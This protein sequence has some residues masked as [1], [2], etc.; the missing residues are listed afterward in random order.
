MTDK[1]GKIAANYGPFPIAAGMAA[2]RVQILEQQ[3]ASGMFGGERAAQMKSE[4][5]TLRKF[6]PQ[7]QQAP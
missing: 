1:R 7:A 5:E 3:L 4:L 6:Y 2:A